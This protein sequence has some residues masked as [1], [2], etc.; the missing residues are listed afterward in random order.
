MS[1]P[2]RLRPSCYLGRTPVFFTICTWARRPHFTDGGNTASLV[3]IEILKIARAQQFNVLVYCLMP[4][5]LHALVVGTDQAASFPQLVHALKQRTS[6]RFKRALG[7]PLWQP[8]FF[9]RTLRPDEDPRRVMHYI[10]MNPVR[11]GLVRRP[12]DYPLWGSSELTRTEVL[13]AIGDVISWS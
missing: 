6:Y 11:A 12:E 2:A 13:D 1:H 10:V 5:H 4:D 9:D 7:T 3:D 8:S